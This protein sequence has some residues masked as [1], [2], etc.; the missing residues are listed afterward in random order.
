M[1]RCIYIGN[2]IT[3]G[4]QDFAFFDTVSDTFL[5]FDG[6]EV[7]SSKE[8]FI[9]AASGELLERCLPLIPACAFKSGC[10]SAD[11]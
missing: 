6:E 1:I 4:D 2:Q 9:A 7:F 5:N 8:E 3:E 10:S 11:V